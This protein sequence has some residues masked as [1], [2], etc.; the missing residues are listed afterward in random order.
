M[1]PVIFICCGTTDIKRLKPF[2]LQFNEIKISFSVSILKNERI[3]FNKL[4]FICKNL[5]KKEDSLLYRKERNL[6]TKRH[7]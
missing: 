7:D 5:N 4:K 6:T 2:E 3:L 1:I